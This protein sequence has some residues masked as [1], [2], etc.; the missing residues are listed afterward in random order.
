M[1]DFTD[2][3][4]SIDNNIYSN[5]R[6]EITGS[7]LNTILND[8]VDA[9][10][11]Q[12]SQLG[13]EVQPLLTDGMEDINIAEWLQGGYNARGA[14]ILT[15]VSYIKR[16]VID[17][18]ALVG[19][20]LSIHLAAYD[21]IYCGFKDGNGNV[22]ATL[23]TSESVS[24]FAQIVVP[25][26]AVQMF[27]S[28]DEMN[29]TTSDA[30][31]R[32]KNFVE[33]GDES[34]ITPNSINSQLPSIGKDIISSYGPNNTYIK[35]NSATATGSA[36]GYTYGIS[37][38]VI[39]GNTYEFVSYDVASPTSSD[40][41]IRFLD[42]N[43]KLCS[44][45]NQYTLVSSGTLNG[46]AYNIFRIVAPLYSV[47]AEFNF[48]MVHTDIA[49]IK[50][51][52]AEGDLETID[53]L[54]I[55]NKNFTPQSFKKLGDTL[56][57]APYFADVISKPVS[58]ANKSVVAFGD[59]ITAGYTSGSTRTDNPYIKILC[60]KVGATLDNRAVA[61]STFVHR[62]PNDI[63]DKV[64][65]YT[66]S[67]DIIWVAGGTNDFNQN[68]TIGSWGDTG[69]DTLY[70]AVRNICEFFK[71]NHPNAYVIFLT[72]VPYTNEA[73]NSVVGFTALDDYRKAIYEVVTYY[74]YSIINGK[75]L[76]MPNAESDWATTM[77]TDGLHPTER[78]HNL[79]AQSISGK[80]F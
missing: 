56:V 61:G 73:K 28:T 51:V 65:E 6:Q 26:S 41:I 23:Q 13:L 79:M 34:Y 12:V 62:Q 50:R 74:G 66:G 31:V 38:K 58:F 35:Q 17:V 68:V 70:G 15:S 52:Y 8:I 22:L 57:F 39:G 77:T 24:G 48:Y 18:S 14:V 32:Y 11:D 71:N 7:K 78:G 49:Y 3:R 75:D 2:A 5:G 29:V 27:L 44:W 33:F 46:K 45:R 60:D 25:T 1:A 10:D 40:N 69:N 72:P 36:T 16:A 76:G 43:G 4:Q 21:M 42:E 9:A 53:W 37:E 47:K 67:A 30:W 59:S 80:L 63:V 19:K 20:V 64:L 55:G 54:G